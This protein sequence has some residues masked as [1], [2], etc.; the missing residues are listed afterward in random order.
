MA[1]NIYK[2]TV[3][4]EKQ[5]DRGEAKGVQKES[6]QVCDKKRV[7]GGAMIG[8]KTAERAEGGRVLIH[9]GLWISQYRPVAGAAHRKAAVN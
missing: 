9:S 4:K 6:R 7:T 8:I 1:K 3:A 2:E 5:P